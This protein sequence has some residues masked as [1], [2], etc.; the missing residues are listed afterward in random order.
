MKKNL[1]ICKLVCLNQVEGT[2]KGTDSIRDALG[3]GTNGV[4]I[5]PRRQE[6]IFDNL[7]LVS[8]T[9]GLRVNCCQPCYRIVDGQCRKVGWRR[10]VCGF[11]T[12]D[13]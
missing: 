10:C 11:Q 8:V 5:R 9:N 6:F 2:Q 1:N 12:F 13:V 3:I 7:Q 4:N